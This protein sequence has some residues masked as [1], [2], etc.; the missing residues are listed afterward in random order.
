M[1]VCKMPV[2]VFC[3][4]G[5]SY[6]HSFSLPDTTGGSDKRGKRVHR[7][8]RERGGG[9]GVVREREREGTP[10]KTS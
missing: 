8:R 7:E 5:F 9:G 10:T 1:S 3:D 2:E 6:I 4:G